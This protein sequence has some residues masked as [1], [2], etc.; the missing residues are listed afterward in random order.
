MH[1]H[2]W[3]SRDRP[4]R[5]RSR[6]A[7]IPFSLS[8]LTLLGLLALSACGDD[9]QPGDAGS[10][11]GMCTKPG[12]QGCQCAEGSKCLITDG[13]PRLKCV[14]NICESTE[15]TSGETGCVCRFGTQCTDKKQSCIDGLCRAEDCAAGSE[16]CD[17][18]N[19]NC[20]PGLICRNG[21]VCV[22]AAGT[23]GGPCK[24]NNTCSDGN[25]CD[26]VQAICVHCEAGSVACQC[27][28][29]GACSPGL[30]CSAGLCIDEKLVPPKEAKCY[31]PCRGDLAT[32][33]QSR[34]C[35]GRLIEGCLDGL[36]CNNGS[37][38]KQGE[39]KPTCD[40]D[41]DCPFFQACLQGGCY[42]NCEVDA[43]C[44]GG[45]GCHDKV[46]RAPCSETVGM[47]ACP[48]GSACDAPD[49][50]NGYCV[51]VSAAAKEPA[52]LPTGGFSL[53]D[54]TLPFSNVDTTKKFAVF[55]QGSQAQDVTIRKLS[56]KVYYKDGKVEDVI[57]SKDAKTGE[58]TK[59]DASK[60]ECPLT[61]LELSVGD[62]KTKDPTLVVKVP[63]NCD[64]KTCPTVTVANAAGSPGVRWEGVFEICSKNGCATPMS[65]TYT[66]LAE[67]Q[68]SGT[69]YYFGT[70]N[71]DGV[72]DWATSGDK[73]NAGNVNNGLIRQWAAFR[74]GNLDSWQEFL[75]VLT[76]TR[77][78]SWDYANV[79]DACSKLNN[80]STTAA[81]YPFTND[82]G[83]RNYVQNKG[84]TP[85][86]TGV[87]GFPMAINLKPT[88]DTAFEGRIESSSA[89]QF[90]ANP[91]LHLEFAGNPADPG[92]C[93]GAIGSDC[94]MFIRDMTATISVGGRYYSNTKTC[95]R[96]YVSR[97]TPW[98]VAGFTQ[99][100]V[101][102]AMT[103]RRYRYECVD[104]QLPYGVDQSGLN[105]GLAGANPVPDGRER[106]RTLR[107]LDG[108]LM[109]QSEMF[110]LFQEEFET[111]IPGHAPIS[112]YGYMILR[113][114]AKDLEPKAFEGVAPPG[115]DKMLPET[116]G[117]QC[118]ADLLSK[119]TVV[120]GR[121]LSSLNATDVGRLVT[122]LID[123]ANV[124]SGYTAI[125]AAEMHVLCEETGLFDGG[126]DVDGKAS[127]SRIMCPAWSK[128]TYFRMTARTQA[129]I[130]ALS[131]NAKPSTP[132]SKDVGTTDANNTPI[133]ST[134]TDADS[135]N[136]VLQQWIQS[137]IVVEVNPFQRCAAASQV[138]CDDPKRLDLLAGKQ[139]WTPD[140]VTRK[141]LL[142]IL[143]EINQ[144]F[145]YKIRFQ[146][147]SGGVIGFAPRICLPGSDQVPYCYDPPVIESIRD[148]IDCLTDIYTNRRAQLNGTDAGKLNGF[149]R[150]SFSSFKDPSTHAYMYDG[151]ERLFA[152]L[153][154]MQGDDALTAAFASRFDIAGVGGAAFEGSQFETS[155][156]DLSG[157]AGFEM[158][159]LY[160]AIQ[161]YQLA[162]DRLY[163][164]GPNYAA[165]LGQA[166]ATTDDESVF[167][168][169]ATVTDYLER[170]I[171][172]ATQKARAWSE[173]AKRYQ[174]F[175]RPD[176]ARAV[177]ERAYAGTYLESVLISNL[178]V[179]IKE[180]STDK[181]LDQ[182]RHEIEQA[183][184]RYRMALLEMR[185]TYQQISDSITYFGFAPEYI[186]FPALD[187][188]DARNSNGFEALTTIARQKLD[189]AKQRE[190]TALESN[191][192]QQT[193][194][195]TFQAELV[196]VRNTY[197]NQLS[198]ICGTFTGDDSVIYPA[199]RK[200]AHLSKKATLLGDPCGRMGSGQLNDAIVQVE[201]A[202]IGLR[203][204]QLR[205]DSTVQQIRNE[206]ERVIAQCALNSKT[207]EIEFQSAN[208]VQGLNAAIAASRIAMSAASRA[209]ESVSSAA[210]AAVCNPPSLFGGAGNC[211]A[212][213]AAAAAIGV[214]GTLTNVVVTGAEAA[215]AG[216]EQ[217]IAA[218][219]NDTARIVGMLRCDAAQ[220]DSLATIK[221]LRLS[222]LEA[223]L[224]GSRAS[225]QALLQSAQVQQLLNSAERWI[226][227]QGEAEEL[228]IDVEAARSD[229]NVRI[230]RNDAVL[231][232]DISF[233]DAIRAVYRATRVYEYY[234][235]QSYPKRD[236]LFLIRM[237]TAG[238]Y[239]LENYLNDLDNAYFDFS[240]TFGNPDT[241]VAILSLRDD[242]LQ[243]PLLDDK[244]TPYSQ[245]ARIDMMRARLRDVNLLD[246]NGYLTIPFS[247]TFKQLSPLTRNHKLRYV[248]ADIVGSDVGDTVGRVYLH[249]AGTGAVHDLNDE[250]EYYRFDDRTAV[251]NTFFNGNRVFDPDVYRNYRLRDRPLVNTLWEF[252]INR[253]D[254]QVNADIDLQSL[255][256]IRL[257]VSYNDFT[258][259]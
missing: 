42:S 189:S 112:A 223:E 209:F 23:E 33:D 181:N 164:M 141:P 15:C 142:P 104:A 49:G 81:C 17:C 102:D 85:I 207:V 98:L 105:A 87:V 20:D 248:E 194:S 245:G 222:M 252:V 55:S 246:E 218:K 234:T 255:S 137:G 41:L 221:N 179:E 201:G 135:C 78:G 27:S 70:F 208:A 227:Q 253:R 65:L 202:G 77:E 119:S 198:D 7:R 136:E 228:L 75:A 249:S 58:Y 28:G 120:A 26:P 66:E 4:G 60:G 171:R 241:R 63:G 213:A 159:K 153:L 244:G 256:D 56:H 167:V 45:L 132:G 169:P 131:C 34:A 226:S 225:N 195:A 161:Y 126:K 165:S 200:Y 100:S 5:N 73:S 12:A 232:A 89:L 157:V 121:Q 84:V 110:V 211:P 188:I 14:E 235:S 134:A 219:Q 47:S 62:M 92:S 199:I 111:F 168:S 243:I 103:N 37:C 216:L 147:S 22:D 258:A 93:D 129:D 140:N 125:P 210:Q 247:T 64:E 86:P 16:S 83:V 144:A 51:P 36:E 113:K 19:G 68:W 31:T 190:V 91:S 163:V 39:D 196:R 172:G 212:A 250:I 114:A 101:L 205:W 99:G 155:G 145:R 97:R 240:E 175:N 238:E 115:S 59:C 239:N 116:K 109:N 18:N 80:G 127:P 154:V 152:E 220:I 146:S 254:E 191:R 94:A 117:V 118:S 177:V 257:L 95:A 122:E 38:V 214:Q 21:K 2:F 124:S 236:Q 71:D 150:E 48:T 230:Y 35:E 44:S 251:V 96:G 130:A 74:A 229:P 182:I 32:T 197:E 8:S 149:L 79:K 170:L 76:A 231:N 133:A 204:A 10:D 183:Q 143:H 106:A 108:A 215:I 50:E 52:P 174:G 233:T 158:V 6:V 148:R 217:G 206:Q 192:S 107:L 139:F 203:A 82:Q 46:C 180:K 24:S 3:L 9:D 162:L 178:M 151:F 90:A 88:N 1:T 187:N 185:D 237:V 54:T 224:E 193:D 128:L 72:Q 166:G 138:L 69:L 123:G 53:L 13:G 173:V 11:G 29:A 40:N 30:S 242:I 176:L 160:Q 156:I 25:R 61:W 67:G 184:L 259:L 57:A 186:P 43:D